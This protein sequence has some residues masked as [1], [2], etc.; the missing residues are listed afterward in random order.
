MNKI[1]K[2]TLI[3]ASSLALFCLSS[4]VSSSITDNAIVDTLVSNNIITLPSINLE[5][6]DLINNEK[7]ELTAS[8]LN[9]W[10]QKAP[11]IVSEIKERLNYKEQIKSYI[12]SKIPDPSDY[13]NPIDY[14][15][16]NIEGIGPAYIV[17]EILGY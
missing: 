5:N 15:P 11:S 8:L 1:S 4:C 16:I 9:S 10:E 14:F 13:L 17:S 12:T 7:I 6:I 3:L 2:L